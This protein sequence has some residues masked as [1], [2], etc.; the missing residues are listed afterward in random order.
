MKAGAQKGDKV[1]VAV[2]LTKLYIF[3]A[4]SCLTL[5]NRDAGYKKTEYADADFIPL[6]YDEEVRIHESLKP[7]KKAK[8]K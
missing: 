7:N 8:K 5:L 3:D 1:G 6:A 4:A 2:D